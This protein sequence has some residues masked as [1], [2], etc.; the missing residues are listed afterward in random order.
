MQRRKSRRRYV[1]YGVGVLV[2]LAAVAIWW[3]PELVVRKRRPSEE[4]KNL[5]RAAVRRSDLWVTVTAGGTVGSSN[6]TIIECELQTMDSGVQGRR[7]VGGGSST[8]LTVVPEGTLVKKGDVLCTLDS[9]MYEELLRQQE[10]TVERCKADHHQT[11]LDVEV[12][13]MAV[14][15]YKEGILLSEGKSLKGRIALAKSE[16]ERA[17][18]RLAWSRRMLSKQYLPVAQVSAEALAERRASLVLEMSHVAADVFHRFEAPRAINELENQVLSA[19]AIFS[20][21]TLRL[22]RNLDR[23]E[24]IRKQVERCTIRAPHDGFVIYF[25]NR[26]RP[27]LIEPGI[28]V[29]QKQPLFTLPDLS[30]MQISTLLHES[31][32][33]EVRDGMR[34]KIR[35][36]GLSSHV[37]EGYITS[38][39]NLPTRNWFSEVPYYV[40]GIKIDSPPKGLL[41][42]MTAEVQISTDRKSEVLTIPAE[43]LSI[44]DG[45]EVCYVA[46]GDGFERREVEVGQATRDELEVTRGLS[47]GEEVVLDPNSLEGNSE[48]VKVDL[49]EA[50]IA[51][52]VETVSTQATQ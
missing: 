17:S 10:M 45:H 22:R 2:A 12:A 40:A 21:Q 23:L 47:E 8:I 19:Q 15:E 39:A 6:E 31:V 41:P 52:N 1:G 27:I 36:E 25:T 4:W 16:L 26:M 14:H 13:Q 24:S 48:V 28:T 18:D 32:V 49:A 29:Y 9:S 37:L 20:Y 34:A 44:E 43:A 38:I 50:D 3:H 5:P 30:R 42:G 33:K 7:L 35:V 11:Q 51:E 46:D